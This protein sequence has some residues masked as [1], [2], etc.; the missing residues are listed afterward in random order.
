MAQSKRGY[1]NISLPV[2]R[3]DT[4]YTFPEGMKHLQSKIRG[5][6]RAVEKRD[7]LVKEK[8]ALVKE[9]DGVIQRLEK[10]LMQKEGVIQRLKAVVPGVKM[11]LEKVERIKRADRMMELMGVLSDREREV[12]DPL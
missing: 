10:E 1:L 4:I 9:R 11:G 2:H 5:L 3:E 6:R 7:V 12:Y 8:D